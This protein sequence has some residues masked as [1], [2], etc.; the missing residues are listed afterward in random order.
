MRKQGSCRVLTEGSQPPVR[1]QESFL[2]QEV[3]QLSWKDSQGQANQES[4]GPSRQRTFWKCVM[5]TG[6]WAP[7]GKA[8]QL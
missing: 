4:Q 5:W 6:S 2:E 8:M 1:V 3:P 7:V